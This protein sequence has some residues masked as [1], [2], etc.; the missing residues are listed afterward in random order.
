MPAGKES[1][2]L[3]RGTGLALAW[4]HRPC[5]GDL[6]VEADLLSPAGGA[7]NQA[8]VVLAAGSDEAGKLSRYTLSVERLQGIELVLRR[9]AAKVVGRP[10]QIRTRRAIFD[11]QAFKDDVMVFEGR[12]IGL[13][14]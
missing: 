4:F 14:V 11:V 1:R 9:N 8:G 3:A 13:P 5:P 2:L 12:L 10:V 6:R 7:F